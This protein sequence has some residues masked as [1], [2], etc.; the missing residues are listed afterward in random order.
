MLIATAVRVT[1]VAIFFLVDRALRRAMFYF[2]A[3][4]AFGAILSSSGASCDVS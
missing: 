1:A 2:V 3:P 4:N